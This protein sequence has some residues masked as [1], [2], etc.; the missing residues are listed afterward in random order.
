MHAKPTDCACSAIAEKI[1]RADELER[2][3]LFVLLSGEHS[4]YTRGELARELSRP[5][6]EP[7]DVSD[8]ITALYTAGLVNV[9]GEQVTP[10][11]GACRMDDLL[12]HPF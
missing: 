2:L 12:E 5:R 4:P 6:R 10:S 11:R 9:S 7:V 1:E 3:V 8:A